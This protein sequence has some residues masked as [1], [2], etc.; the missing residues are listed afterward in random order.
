[1]LSRVNLESGKTLLESAGLWNT[2]WNDDD[3]SVELDL[4]R[5]GVFRFVSPGISVNGN[6]N[7]FLN[8]RKKTTVCWSDGIITNT[9]R[10]LHNHNWVKFRHTSYFLIS[11]FLISII[12][13]VWSNCLILFKIIVILQTR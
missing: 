9:G 11:K 6:N 5:Y 10:L 7:S 12:Y 1:M 8:D 13:D 2:I 3:N 4:G